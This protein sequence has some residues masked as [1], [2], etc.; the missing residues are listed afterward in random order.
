LL[1]TPAAQ[2][3][4]QLRDPA[5]YEEDGRTYLLYSVAGE[6]GIAMAELFD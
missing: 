3:V 5:V 1:I 2:A 4:H 6:S